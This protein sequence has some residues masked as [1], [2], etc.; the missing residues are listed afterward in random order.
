MSGGAL[1]LTLGDHGVHVEVGPLHG[2]IGDLVN[3]QNTSFFGNGQRGGIHKRMG[4]QK[5]TSTTLAGPIY[6]IYPV[7]FTDPAP[8]AEITDNTP[9][10]LTDDSFLT[11]TE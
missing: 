3:A 11:L 2:D 6:A 5:I 7:T 1:V 9:V 4:L 10:A 8:G